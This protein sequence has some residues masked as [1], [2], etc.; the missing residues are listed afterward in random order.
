MENRAGEP[1]ALVV[2]LGK[3]VDRPVEDLL[4][5]GLVHDLIDFPASIDGRQASQI[6][7]ETQILV[8]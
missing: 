3:L 5:S 2:A 7:D 8:N 4:Q 1:D 6:G